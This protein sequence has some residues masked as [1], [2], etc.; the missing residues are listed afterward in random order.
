[1]GGSDHGTGL[2]FATVAGAGVRVAVRLTPRAARD[3][4]AAGPDGRPVLRLRVAAPPVE[5][6][7]NAALVEY[8][9]RSLGVR[10]SDVAIVSGD[11]GRLKLLELSGDAAALLA[12]LADWVERERRR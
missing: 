5:G 2:P 10:K 4:V 11:R 6:A 8:V 3:G 7:A 9:A 1:M 12:R